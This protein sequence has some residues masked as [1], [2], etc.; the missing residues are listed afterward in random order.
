[1][2]RALVVADSHG[3]VRSLINAVAEYEPD[4]VF[5]LGDHNTDAAALR[6]RVS[7]PVLGVAGNCDRGD[8]DAPDLRA[9]RFGGALVLLTHGHLFDVRSRLGIE[10]LARYAAQRGCACALFGH[11]HI[12]FRESVGG[13]LLI[14]PGRSGASPF[15]S[16]RPTCCILTADGGVL[17]AGQCEIHEGS[18]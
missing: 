16:S 11:T 10:R 12:P 13:V 17:S 14:N 18:V 6:R 8:P 2:P 5:H 15:L 7:V 1:M 4:I 3:D 9:E